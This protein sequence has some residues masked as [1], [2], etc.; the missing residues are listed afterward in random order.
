[1]NL[2]PTRASVFG[3]GLVACVL[4]AAT[5]TGCGAGQQSQTATQEPAV[6]GASGAVGKVALRDVRIR[7]EVKGAALAPG[8]S[9]ELLFV[10]ANQSETDSDKLVG[11]TSDIGSVTLNPANP[12]IPAGRSLI[13]G[14]PEGIDAEALQAVSNAVKATATVKLSKPLAN[15]ITY[16]FVF[17]FERGGQGTIGVP[18]TAGDTARAEQPSPAGEGH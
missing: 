2:F 18:V 12:E 17:K 9:V 4:I 11:I 16:D 13:V 7:A 6:N 10:A 8:E 3:A 14:K 1:V 5:L 15:A